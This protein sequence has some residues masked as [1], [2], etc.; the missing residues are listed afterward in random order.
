MAEI[1]PG[2]GTLARPIP[3]W[4]TYLVLVQGTWRSMRVHRVNLMMMFLGSAAIQGTQLAFISVLLGAFGA[5]AGWSVGEV[6]FL[7]G[8][9]LTAHGVCTINFGQHRGSAQAIRNGD[10]DRFLLRPAG[11]LMQLLTRHFNPGTIGD[12]VLGLAILV[13]AANLI[14]IPWSAG[15]VLFL[16]LAALGGGLVEAGLQIALSALDFRWGPLVRIKDMVDR[17]LTDF[18]AYPMTI[19]GTAGTWLLTV[20]IPLAF[21]AYLPTTVLLGRT[22]ELVVPVWT[23]QLSPLAGPLLLVLGI[24]FFRY[25]SRFY[26]SP[27]H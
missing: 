21:M 24:A 17:V 12:L 18:G 27:G 26:A 22:D 25:M 7:Y 23:A 19:F 2:R 1:R 10:W 9:R 20:L 8:L 4:R 5:I 3:A 11:P 16:A 14:G 13:T 6:A 15:M